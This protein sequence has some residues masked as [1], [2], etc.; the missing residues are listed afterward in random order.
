MSYLMR[1]YKA[2]LKEVF[3]FVLLRTDFKAKPNA[4]F[5][6]QLVDYEI[7]MFGSSSMDDLNGTG[8][9]N[10]PVL[11]NENTGLFDGLQGPLEDEQGF[12]EVASKVKALMMTGKWQQLGQMGE[13]FRDEDFGSWPLWIIL[14]RRVLYQV[15]AYQ[16]NFVVEK[17]PTP[18]NP[19]TMLIYNYIEQTKAAI[20]SHLGGS[21]HGFL[22]T[23]QHAVSHTLSI[24]NFGVGSIFIDH[25]SS[26]MGTAYRQVYA[27]KVK[28]EEAVVKLSNDLV[29][30]ASIVFSLF[31]YLQ[32]DSSFVSY[33]EQYESSLSNRLSLF[34]PIEHSPTSVLM[35]VESEIA[36]LVPHP[37]HVD[38]IQKML[39]DIHKVKELKTNW[40]SSRQSSTE[41]SKE[42]DLEVAI[43][44]STAWPVT[45]LT[46]ALETTDL[47]SS[48]ST[49]AVSSI[50]VTSLPL[51]VYPMWNSFKT[52][53]ESEGR[54][55]ALLPN[56]GE[57]Q[58]TTTLGGKQYTLDVTTPMML[59]LCSFNDNGEATTIEGLKKSLNLPSKLLV[60]TLHS[61]SQPSCQL[62]VRQTEKPDSPIAEEDVFVLNEDFTSK[63]RRFKVPNLKY[64]HSK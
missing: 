39:A 10:A 18:D 8:T 42:A 57:A 51:D 21:S 28:G 2:P 41:A 52:F 9:H 27:G 22:E 44:D 38:R 20:S 12:K 59:V 25:L 53:V 40:E 50:P 48:L 19:T 7:E 32:A 61:L 35:P 1:R 34:L 26:A 29:K 54:K 60:Q 5:L 37:A 46:K 30:T 58:L 13:E 36:L 62:L 33:L 16:M 49:M 24:A 47:N 14:L 6:A 55:V 17:V 15:V 4:G 31:N 11:T 45:A 64:P 23:L 63:L 43:L 3:A 56:L